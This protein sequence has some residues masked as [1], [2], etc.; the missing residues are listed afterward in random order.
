MNEPWYSEGL[1]FQCTRCGN[2]CTGPP[3]YVWVNDDE[4]RVLADFKGETVAEFMARFTRVVE[5]V[6]SLRE[7]PNGDCVFFERE[8]GC[9]VYPHRPRQCRTWPFWESNLQ[10][11]AD[12]KETRRVCPGA[13]QGELISAEEITRRINVIRL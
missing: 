1:A 6:R 7:K 2:C 12:W 9:T 3:G 4:V 10:T 8:K 13:G 5:E 11:P